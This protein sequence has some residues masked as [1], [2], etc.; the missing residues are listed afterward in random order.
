MIL[1]IGFHTA[2]TPALIL[3]TDLLSL[4]SMMIAMCWACLGSV[5]FSQ[6]AS[7]PR[8]PLEAVGRAAA[9]RRRDLTVLPVA[10]H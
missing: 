1:V 10:A 2:E 5:C 7:G 8:L 4:S 3:K 9:I 6:L